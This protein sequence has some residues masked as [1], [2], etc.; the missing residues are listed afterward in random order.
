MAGPGRGG[1]DWSFRIVAVLSIGGAATVFIREGSHVFFEVLFEDTLLFLEIVPKVLAGT[2]IGALIRLLVS[3][4]T[5][6]ATLGAGSGL[7]GLGIATLAGILI[8][9]GPFT[10]FPLSAALLVAGADAGAAA[11]FVSAWLL[12]GL[13]RAIVWEVPF[14]GLDFVGLRMLVSAPMPILLGFAARAAFGRLVAEH[15]AEG[16]AE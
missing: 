10:V 9:A 15:S 16:R 12:L 4:E 14:F 3:K 2:L 1:I 6:A 5:I 13:N 8:P 11:A 7:R